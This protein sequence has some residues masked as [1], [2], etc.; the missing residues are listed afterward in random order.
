[1]DKLVD[2]QAGSGEVE[3]LSVITKP[4]VN[5]IVQLD[6]DVLECWSQ[7]NCTRLDDSLIKDQCEVKKG[8]MAK[9]FVSSLGEALGMGSEGEEYDI[10]QDYSST[11]E[12]IVSS[13]KKPTE[14]CKKFSKLD[15]SFISHDGSS[16]N[17]K[18]YF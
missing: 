11:T 15:G 9:G 3:I 2:G 10:Y 14:D 1:M 13:T 5:L 12:A 7:T 4:F 17:F 18:T 16:K 8:K 6:K